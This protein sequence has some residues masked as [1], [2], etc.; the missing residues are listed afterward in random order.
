VRELVEEGNKKVLRGLKPPWTQTRPVW[1]LTVV[2]F[3]I[4]Y[5]VDE[6]RNEVIHRRACEAARQDH[7]GDP[8][9]LVSVRDAK[10]NLSACLDE[11]QKQGIV[12]THHGR[13][14]SVMIGVEGYDL[15]DVM[16]MLNPNFW[17]M[18][19]SRRQQ[20]RTPLNEFEKELRATRTPAKKRKRG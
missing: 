3:R 9:R 16:L 12:V 20:A 4:F 15:A 6:E 8:M 5:D 17:K 19:E 13:P 11:S 2:P 1:Q 7:E 10:T 18:I 14:K